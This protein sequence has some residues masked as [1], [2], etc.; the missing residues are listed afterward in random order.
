MATK[1]EGEGLSRALVVG[2]LVEELFCG[3]PKQSVIKYT[4]KCQDPVIDRPCYFWALDYL[5]FEKY[6][7]SLL[8]NQIYIS[9]YL[10][11]MVTQ[12]LL[13]TC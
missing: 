10:Y 7:L 13:R 1:L 4:Y 2:I 12:N 3:C 6:F 8:L 11:Q 9:W 5:E